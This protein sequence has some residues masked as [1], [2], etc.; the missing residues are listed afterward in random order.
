[1]E[2]KGKTAIIT[3]AS[4][5]IGKQLAVELGRR[6]A[7][8]VVAARTVERHRRL[9]GSIGETVDAVKAAGGD[10]VAVQMDLMVPSDIEALGREAIA[11]FGGIDILVNN[12]ADT[13]G[14]TPSILDLDRSEWLRQFDTNLHG[15]FS[16]M[17]AVLP[18]MVERGGGI[19]VNLTSGAGD[20]MPPRPAA[21]DGSGPIHIG[22]RLAYGA[23]KA[24]LNRLGNMI[25][26]E[27]RQHGVAVVTV[28]PGFTRTELVDLMGERGMVD[29][30]A[31]I[32]MEV[33]VKTIIHVL[34]SADPLAYTG[35]IL[36]AGPF[37]AENGL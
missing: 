30:E 28:D 4:R 3:G 9:P 1:M 35:T 25:A 18:S 2:I 16:L 32:P 34:T 17:Q 15:P 13:S 6:G 26:P 37:V 31:A 19:I 20:L 33:P 14:G 24:A 11:H 23:S 27:L 36:R 7:N 29:P 10:A 8:V 21:P 12:A 22:E 5:G